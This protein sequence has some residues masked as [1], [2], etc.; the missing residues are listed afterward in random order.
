M[1]RWAIIRKAC[2]GEEEESMVEV[3]WRRLLFCALAALACGAGAAAPRAN[4]E[5]YLYQGADRDARLVERAKKEGPVVLYSTMTV[6]DG[7][8]LAAAFERKYGVKVTHWRGSAEKIVQRTLAG[9]RAGRKEGDVIETNAHRL[10]ALYREKMLQ[11]FLN[12]AVDELSSPAFPPPHPPDG[13]Y[14]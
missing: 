11:G 1:K 13:C 2:G 10:E 4:R 7:R 3:F 5:I 14:R 6:Q 8:V 9:S 12:P